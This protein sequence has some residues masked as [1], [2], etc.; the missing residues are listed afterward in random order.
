MFFILLLFTVEFATHTSYSS[1]IIENYA[2]NM[3]EF[4]TNITHLFCI[5]FFLITHRGVLFLQEEHST[6]PDMAAYHCIAV[7]LGKAGHLTQL[8]HLIQSLRKGPIKKHVR[9]SPKQLNWNGRLEPDIAIYNAVSEYP[10][11][12][13]VF[14]S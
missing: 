6:Y 2:C 9:G 12:L 1:Y 3:W 5:A 4:A 11:I 7:T 10:F 8:L 13:P 14:Y